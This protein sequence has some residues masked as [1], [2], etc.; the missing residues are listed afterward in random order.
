MKKILALI[1]IAAAVVFS[2]CS[3][4]QTPVDANQPSGLY[5]IYAITSQA[6]LNSAMQEYPRREILIY[7][8]PGYNEYDHRTNYPVLYL[9]HDYGG[10]QNYYRGLY[11]LAETMDE[12]INSG[13]IDPMI[14]VTPDASTGLGGGFYTNS[15]DTLAGYPGQSYGGYMADFIDEVIDSVDMTYNTIR[16]YRY[17]GI[18]GH[19]MGGYGAIKLAMQLLRF[20]SA[21]SMSGPLSFYGSYPA[22]TTFLGFV[23]MFPAMFNEN[24]FTPGDTAGF[25]A[26]T[27]GTGKILTNMMFAMG[28]AFTP[29]DPADPDTT[30]AHSFT[31]PLTAFNGKVDL[32]FDVNG[33]LA[34]SVWDLWMLNDVTTMYRSGLGDIFDLQVVDLYVDAG[35]EDNFYFNLQSRVFGIYAADA[36]TEPTISHY[37]IYSDYGNNLPADHFTLIGDRLKD[38]IKFHNESFKPDL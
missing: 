6:L 19:G 15:P 4:R 24:G 14:V 38:V 13:E 5:S 32:P 12:L 8:P 7:T 36:F 25:Y 30:F 35:A 20:G 11:G 17:R 1:I 29:H 22:D 10:D 9:L 33:N 28:A 31:N 18:S 37:E 2:G 16:D 27:P 21:S 23:S 26:I 3:N 34:S